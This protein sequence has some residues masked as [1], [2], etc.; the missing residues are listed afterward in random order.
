MARFFL[1]QTFIQLHAYCTCPSHADVIACD[2]IF[3]KNNIRHGFDLAKLLHEH[4]LSLID[5]TDIR[6]SYG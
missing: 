3:S 5:H 1:K 6:S 2:L 4:K